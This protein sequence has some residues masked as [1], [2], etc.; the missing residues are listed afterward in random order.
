MVGE[1]YT[2]SGQ[3]SKIASPRIKYLE[4]YYG[5]EL[6]MQDIANAIQHECFEYLFNGKK[7]ELEVCF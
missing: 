2:I 3:P 4:N 5:F 1:Y 7:A 6:K